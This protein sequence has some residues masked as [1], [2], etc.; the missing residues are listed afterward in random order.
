MREGKLPNNSTI[1]T[2]L[3]DEEAPNE[4]YLFQYDRIKTAEI[5]TSLNLKDKVFNLDNPQETREEGFSQP[6]DKHHLKK[7]MS[8]NEFV[9]YS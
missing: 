2:F 9:T 8:L 5:K 6:K 1:L 4:D 7:Y 3:I